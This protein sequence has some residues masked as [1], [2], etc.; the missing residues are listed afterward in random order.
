MEEEADIQLL[1]KGYEPPGSASSVSAE[2]VSEPQPEPEPPEASA[3]A[4]AAK[5]AQ[6]QRLKKLA[7]K[8]SAEEEAELSSRLG[9]F[10]SI[11][12][13]LLMLY[14]VGCC[15]YSQCFAL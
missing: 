10:R 2:P 9:S 6:G 15:G 14:C 13:S 1:L 7:K 4:A 11:H 3:A 8:L 5:A 12:F